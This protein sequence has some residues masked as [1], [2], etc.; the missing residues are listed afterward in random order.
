MA[1]GRS[2]GAKSKRRAKKTAARG[3]APSAKRPSAKQTAAKKRRSSTTTP[4]R[5]TRPKKRASSKRRRKAPALS[6]QQRASLTRAINALLVV[7]EPRDYWRQA[8]KDL[9]ER[10]RDQFIALLLRFGFDRRSASARLGWVTRLRQENRLELA[11]Q[12]EGQLQT[13]LFDRRDRRGRFVMVDRN[14]RLREMVRNRD[15]RWVRFLE[16]AETEYGLTA[17]E[18]ENEWFSPKIR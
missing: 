15:R 17:D 9:Y 3:R 4:T 12:R 8:T 14:A 10:R 6:P 2:R 13:E 7:G 5:P 18:A 16:I 11:E 1:Q